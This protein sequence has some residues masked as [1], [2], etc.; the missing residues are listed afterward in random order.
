VKRLDE[1][2]IEWRC[3]GCKKEWPVGDVHWSD[4]AETNGLGF[5]DECMRTK[6]ASK[7]K[8]RCEK[9]DTLSR[10]TVGELRPALRM[11]HDKNLCEA[12]V[13]TCS[14]LLPDE[15]LYKYYG[16]MNSQILKDHAQVDAAFHAHMHR[17]VD[18]KNISRHE[19]TDTME[20]KFSL[21]GS[22]DKVVHWTL[23][24]FNQLEFG[25]SELCCP[26]IFDAEAKKKEEGKFYLQTVCGENVEGFALQRVRDMLAAKT[27]AVKPPGKQVEIIVAHQNIIR[28][29][30]LK[31]MQF[32]TTAWLNFNGGNCTMTQ[33]RLTRRGDVIC[34]FF[35]DHGSRMPV[36]AY[37][38]N[39]QPDY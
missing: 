1:R 22:E 3:K 18:H 23:S 12:D 4:E 28:Y 29:F 30:F 5:C 20:F 34:D 15:D 38:F 24:E 8:E 10:F 37:T 25:D 26:W 36:S 39:K 2:F 9:G 7:I 19:R 27:K 21:A 16:Q 14:I 32:D 31:A 33:L 13:D 17:T 6:S 35:G 11:P